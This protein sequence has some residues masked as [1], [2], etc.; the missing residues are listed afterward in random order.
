MTLEDVL[1][2]IEIS[3]EPLVVL[4]PLLDA[5][6]LVAVTRPDGQ[7]SVFT[8]WLADGLALGSDTGAFQR[9][10]GE[11][12]ADNELTPD[13]LD[14]LEELLGCLADRVATMRAA[15]LAMRRGESVREVMS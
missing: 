6:G 14:E 12:L 11:A 15:F 7:Q 13:E 4:R 10:L 3:A 8:G 9:R 1:G 5:C 2:L